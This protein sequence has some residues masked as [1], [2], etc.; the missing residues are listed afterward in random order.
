MAEILNFF[1]V[2]LMASAIRLG[3]PIILAALG[4]AIC[5]RAGVL[6]LALEGKMLLGSFL[7][8]ISAYYIQN[9]PFFPMPPVAS[10][11]FALLVAM[12]AGGLLGAFFALLYIKFEV[13]LVILAIAINLMLLELT[14]FVMRVMFGDV[15][16]WSDPSIVQLPAIQIPILK[17]IPGIARLFSGY[18]IIVYS[19]LILCIAGYFVLF[20]T[21]FGRH[22]RAV[23]ENIEAARTVGIKVRRVQVFALVISGA[24]AALGGAFLSVGH[25]TLFTRNMSNGRGWLGISAALFGF[26]HPIAVY[27]SGLFFGFADAAAIRLQNVTDIPPS[28]VQVIPFIATI[29][30]LVLVALRIKIATYLNKRKFFSS[31]HLNT[32][33]EPISEQ[34]V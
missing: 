14:V 16:T 13:N 6:N 26:N 34:N 28:I 2:P 23:G 7:G 5:N 8:I 27:F 29:L 19:A 1:T 25:L 18:N 20:N 33:K 24:L 9:N 15:G 31:R 3:T 12:M 30:A 32:D 17:D 22:I 11:Y 10:T 4:G 21:K